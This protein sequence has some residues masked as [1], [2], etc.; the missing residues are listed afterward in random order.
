MKKYLALVL[1]LILGL[2]VCGCSSETEGVDGGFVRET[3]SG[4]IKEQLT[5]NGSEY[6]RVVTGN[7]E[8]MDFLITG[9][10]E[11]D[12]EENISAGDSVEIDCVHWYEPS[13]YEILKLITVLEANDWG[14]SLSVKNVASAGATLVISQS[15]GSPSG[16]LWYGPAYKIQSLNGDT[17]EDVPYVTEA[18]VEWTEEI[19]MVEMDTDC[20]IVLS[21]DWLYGNLPEGQYRIVKEFMD[22][23]S[24]GD[25]DKENYYADFDIK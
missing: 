21:W 9:T 4:I 24:S 25:Y 13:T 19:Y 11:I 8:V 2:T 14:L 20:E 7:N 10:T 18:D 1:A 6:I 15:S 5:E 17:W 12:G 16:E 22:F 23:R 3:Y